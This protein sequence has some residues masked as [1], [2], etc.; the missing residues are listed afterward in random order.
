[1][2]RSI[3]GSGLLQ[4]TSIYTVSALLN[5]LLAFLLLPILTRYLS[6][7]D[8]GIV[9]TFLAISTLLTGIC[10]CGTTTTL[11]TDY[12]HL[13]HSEFPLFIG[14]LLA[15]ILLASGVLAGLLWPAALLGIQPF[16]LGGLDPYIV[17]LAATSAATMAIFILTTTL[18]QLE[19]K[20]TAYGVFFNLKTALELSISLILIITFGMAWDGRIL[21]IFTANALFSIIALLYLRNRNIRLT[22]TKQ[23]FRCLLAIGLPMIISHV[24]MWVYGMVDRILISSIENTESTGLYAVGFRFGMVVNLIESSFSIAWLP[25]F[26]ESLARGTPADKEKIVQTTYLYTAVLIAFAIAFGM[27][28]THL[29]HFMV[30]KAYYQAGDFVLLISLAFGVS[31]ISKLFSGYI[32]AAGR[33]RLY[34]LITCISA[35]VHVGLTYI[36][37]IHCGLIGC[38]WATLIS[39]CFGAALTISFGLRN[40]QMPWKE[41]AIHIL[42][43]FG[44]RNT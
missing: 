15:M 37:L 4:R 43:R 5:A 6:P 38:A 29:L 18:L 35:A 2:I 1:M 19:K 14:S 30:D 26:F 9:E 28:G 8:Y 41:T 33:N 39:M 24:A 27:T 31:G 10:I 34:A 21:A 11:S 36:L 25:F 7:S 40:T 20:A 42:K 23:R 12:F 22:L 44:S 13:K 17:P 3:L 16:L 32:I